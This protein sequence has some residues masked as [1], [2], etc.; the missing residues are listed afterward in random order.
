MGSVIPDQSFACAAT[1]S[2]SFFLADFLSS[3]D[4]SEHTGGRRLLLL[5]R[6]RFQEKYDSKIVTEVAECKNFYEAEPYHQQ[7]LAR[8]GRFGKPQSAAKGCS[9]PIRCYG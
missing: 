6:R 2:F 7:Y 1:S 4:A 5:L 3:P 9:D 8:G